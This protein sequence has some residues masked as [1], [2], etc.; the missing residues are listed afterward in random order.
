MSLDGFS[1]GPNV[2]SENPLGEGGERLHE[3]LF[4]SH[5]P[6]DSS[7]MEEIVKASGAVIVGGTTYK[8]AIINAWGGKSPFE[9]P[10][11]VVTHSTNLDSIAGFEYVDKGIHEAMRLARLAAGEKDIWLLGGANLVQQFL[12]AKLV[13]ELQISLVHVLLG[14][15]VRLFDHKEASLTE[16][17]KL[18]IVE[19]PGVTH[20]KYRVQ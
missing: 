20:V 5:T 10:A 8:T 12:A 16:L 15:G 9:V 6:A 3:W 7:V 17:K 4:N 11:F 2:S 13:D 18:R 19:S 14:R 1:A